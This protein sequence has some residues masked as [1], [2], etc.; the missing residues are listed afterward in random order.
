[1]KVSVVVNLDDGRADG[2]VVDSLMVVCGA[3]AATGSVVLS[4]RF[5]IG[6]FLGKSS[7][8]AVRVCI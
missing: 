5:L 6:G 8:T 3:G 1:V 4:L 2:C 7:S